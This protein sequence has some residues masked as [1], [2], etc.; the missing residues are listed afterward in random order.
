MRAFSKIQSPYSNMDNIPHNDR[1]ELAIA[2]L[3]SQEYLNYTTIARKWNIEQITLSRRHRGVTDS[4]VDQYSYI[5]KALTN[6][7]ENVLIRYIKDLNIKEFPSISQIVKNLAE[8][9]ANKKLNY[10]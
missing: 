4:K 10:N 7:Q 2:N 6:M 9:L 3:E 5:I 1:I 8:E